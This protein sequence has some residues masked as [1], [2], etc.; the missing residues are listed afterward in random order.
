MATRTVF[1]EVDL[2]TVIETEFFLVHPND[3]YV[4]RIIVLLKQLS[5][6][7][8]AQEL[9]AALNKL[10]HEKK[11]EFCVGMADWNDLITDRIKESPK[12][13]LYFRRIT[14]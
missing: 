4:N 8:S 13:S 6:N 9:Q 2:A 7:Y 1:H 3:L 11:I 10:L 14:P 5:I 12:V